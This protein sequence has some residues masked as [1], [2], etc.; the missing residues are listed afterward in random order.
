VIG[1]SNPTDA[2]HDLVAAD[3]LLVPLVPPL[4]AVLLLL[5]ADRR[6]G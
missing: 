3:A 1:P 5:L 2:T 6:H 4:A